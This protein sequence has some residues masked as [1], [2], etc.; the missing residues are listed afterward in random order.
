MLSLMFLAAVAQQDV[1][2]SRDQAEAMS[3]SELVEL[4]LSDLPHGEIVAVQ[5]SDRG[6]GPH[7]E[8]SDPSLSYL[9]FFEQGAPADETFCQARQII[10]TF[11]NLDGGQ[12]KPFAERQSSDPKR[13]FAVSGRRLMAVM[14]D[15]KS[16]AELPAAAYAQVDGDS[17]EADLRV[18]YRLSRNARRGE[19]AAPD[20]SCMNRLERPDAACD[21]TEVLAQ[22]DWSNL[23][24]ARHSQF[25]GEPPQSTIS[26]GD[27]WTVRFR[28]E[29]D[30]QSIALD[31]DHPP[32]F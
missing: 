21:A 5:R 15:E 14:R 18:L 17:A 9:T 19:R 13:L 24:S 16:C 22:L 31:C 4:L 27:C 25:M 11:D 32:P 7:G 28:G 12:G 6:P 2:L 8:A 1:I 23:S 30:Q 3:D 26:F 29:R 10:V 20:T